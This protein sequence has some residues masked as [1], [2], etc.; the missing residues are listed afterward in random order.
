MAEFLGAVI[1][2]FQLCSQWQ[3]DRGRGQVGEHALQ[4]WK[5]SLGIKQKPPLLGNGEGV[6]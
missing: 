6:S 2:S 3:L 1:V 5:S 4:C